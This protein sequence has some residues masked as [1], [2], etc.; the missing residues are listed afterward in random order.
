[1]P[2]NQVVGSS[3]LLSLSN[4]KSLESLILKAFSFFMSLEI[5]NVFSRTVETF[6]I[7]IAIIVKT[8]INLITIVK[9]FICVVV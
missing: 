9:S 7:I 8:L 3:S 1:M 5:Y 4:V 2:F 6:R